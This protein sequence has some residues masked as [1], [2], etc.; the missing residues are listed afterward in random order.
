MHSLGHPIFGD[1]DY[2]GTTPHGVQVT[3]K[4]KQH[5]N[6][7]LVIMPRQALHAKVLGFIHPITGKPLRFES[8]LPEDMKELIEN[9]SDSSN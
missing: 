5:V 9:L 7:L 3:T 1:L 6:N 2:E 8:D 4:L